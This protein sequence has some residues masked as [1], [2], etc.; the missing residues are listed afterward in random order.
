MHFTQVRSS[1]YIISEGQYTGGGFRGGGLW[2]SVEPP[3]TQ[4]VIFMGII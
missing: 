3:L 1:V 4:N 2:G